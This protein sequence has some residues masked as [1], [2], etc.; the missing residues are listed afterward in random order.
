MSTPTDSTATT[1]TVTAMTA[2]DIFEWPPLESDPSIFTNYLHSIGLTDEWEIGECYGLDEDCLG[3]VPPS[4]VAMIVNAARL[5][6]KEDD[7]GDDENGS[8]GG[9]AQDS[10]SSDYHYYMKQSKTLDNA[11][12]IIACL[13]AV[14]NNPGIVPIQE[15]SILANFWDV[16]QDQTPEERCTSLESFAAFKEAHKSYAMQGQSHLAT[17]QDQVNHHYTA[18]VLTP[19]K[20]LIEFDGTRNKGPLLVAENV[21]SVV[22]GTAAELQ[23]RLSQGKIS[24]SLSVMTL[25]SQ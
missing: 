19:D 7:D 5:Q 25:V 14:F 21:E 8:G 10:N 12:G 20:R 18:F 9:A 24:E 2:T 17:S 4:C 3:F 16:V 15:N 22:H 11:C 6:P 1:G 23:K 13:H